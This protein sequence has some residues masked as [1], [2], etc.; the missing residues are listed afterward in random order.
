MVM[1]ILS[2]L[3]SGMSVWVFT[4]ST[5]RPISAK[6][7]RNLEQLSNRFRLSSTD[8]A[9]DAEDYAKMIRQLSSLL[10]SG[11]SNTAAFELLEQIWDQPTG[12]VNA[13]IY[14][15]CR[16]S[17]MQVYTGGTLQEGLREHAEH[18][19][20]YPRLWNR[21]AWCFAISERSGAALAELL[22]QLATDLE[23]SADMRRTLDTA[24]AGPRT[25]SKLLT[26]LPLIGLALG[27]LLGVA[28]LK[29][30]FTHPLGK[31][32][33]IGGVLLWVANRWWC[34]NMLAKILR[35]ASV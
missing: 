4:R 16:R 27:Q 24:L 32:A 11:S 35:Q 13:D 33:L 15:A 28:P 29:V 21:L 30:L 8:E 14:K 5:R 18:S 25:T 20:R 2:I 23:N 1:I 3:L 10:K 9:A 6:G 26:F 34:K 17:L 19:H 22:D 7:E 12:S 31:V